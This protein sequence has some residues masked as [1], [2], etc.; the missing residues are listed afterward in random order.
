MKK[1]IIKTST[2]IFVTGFIIGFIITQYLKS[3]EIPER[4]RPVD[5]ASELC[6]Y[7]SEY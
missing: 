4:Y 7:H 3:I 5:I 6:D 2:I 1:I